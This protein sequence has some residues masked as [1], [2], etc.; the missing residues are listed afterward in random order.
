MYNSFLP[1]YG[2]HDVLLQADALHCPRH[3][4]M[5]IK[6]EVKNLAE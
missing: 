1:A 6:F 5:K 4:S 3:L 2:Y